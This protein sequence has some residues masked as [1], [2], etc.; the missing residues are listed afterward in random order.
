MQTAEQARLEQTAK[1]SRPADHAAASQRARKVSRMRFNNEDGATSARAIIVSSLFLVLLAATLLFG[2]HAAIDPLLR[3]ATAAREARAV[4]DVVYSMP[5]GKFCRHM[6]FD[7]GTGDMVEGT[8][9]R[10]P[11]DIAREEFR[12]TGRNAGSGFAWGQH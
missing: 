5:D 10:C 9:E 1:W 8:V 2:G 3:S 11:D 6:T 4:G 12:S 7:N